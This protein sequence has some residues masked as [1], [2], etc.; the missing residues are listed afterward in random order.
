MVDK[1]LRIPGV[2]G[3]AAALIVGAAHAD[4]VVQLLTQKNVAF[5]LIQPVDL[6]SKYGSMSVAEYQRKDKGEWARN[7]PGTLG[8]VLNSHHKPP[9]VI[10]LPN[11]ESYASMNMAGILMARAARGGGT[12]FPD[13]VISQISSLPGIRI[14]KDSISRNGY[15]VIFHAWLK[16]GDGSEKSVWT[17]VGTKTRGIHKEEPKTLE[18]KL[19]EKTEEFKAADATGGGKDGNGGKKGGNHGAGDPPGGNGDHDSLVPGDV[20]K[21]NETISRIGM[22]TLVSFGS[23]RAEVMKVGRLSD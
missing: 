15:D 21:G 4:K 10:E 3:Q 19:L 6:D 23:S 7:S 9:P 16:Q 17:R 14:D 13:N 20:R 8:H 18:A 1:L 12:S 22:D 5:A 2:S 11:G